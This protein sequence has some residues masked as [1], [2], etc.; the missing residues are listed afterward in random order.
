MDM[1]WSQTHS[2]IISQKVPSQQSV[3]LIS[4]PMTILSSDTDLTGESGPYE[5]RPYLVSLLTLSTGTR[6]F[7]TIL[8]QS[9]QPVFDKIWS[10]YFEGK[11]GKLAIHPM[12]NFVVAKA[13]ERLDEA[14]VERV[15][16]ECKAVSGGRGM[17][18]KSLQLGQRSVLMG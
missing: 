18:S 2:W 13:V 1:P 5:S 11:I 3:C 8:L 10:V 15:V 7:E 9:P 16:T 12:S 6:I 17:I 4:F 14:G